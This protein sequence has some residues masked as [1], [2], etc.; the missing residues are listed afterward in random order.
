LTVVDI[1]IMPGSDPNSINLNSMGVVPVA[2]LTT[3]DL[4]ASTVDPD[5]V[6][7]ASAE[8]VR[9]TMED[10]DNDGDIDMLFHFNAQDLDLDENS[11][12]AT[13][14]GTTYGGIAVEGTDT[15]NIVPKGKA[16]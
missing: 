3:D 2:V 7:F 5:T 4:D 10:V 15:V 9:W 14:L 1:D 6:I 16:K 8:P 13:L 12:E 11:T